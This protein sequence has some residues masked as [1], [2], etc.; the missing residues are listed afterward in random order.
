MA[1]ESDQANAFF[2]ATVIA[3]RNH[4]PDISNKAELNPGISPKIISNN[5]ACANVIARA[6]LGGVSPVPGIG[7]IN[8]LTM[9]ASPAKTTQLIA[10]YKRSPKNSSP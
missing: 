7:R 8:L 10:P 2:S 4:S 1:L 9:K 5:G 6:T 3:T